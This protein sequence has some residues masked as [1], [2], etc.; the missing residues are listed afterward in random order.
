MKSVNIL[1]RIFLLAVPFALIACGDDSSSASDDYSSASETPSSSS[2]TE[3]PESLAAGEFCD[4]RDFNVYATSEIGAL[5]WMTGN[6]KYHVDGSKC[7]DDK[8]SNCDSHGRLY[9]WTQAMDLDKSLLIGDASSKVS[10]PH[11]RGICPEGWHVPDTLEWLYLVDYVGGFSSLGKYGF[12]DTEPGFYS[13]YYYRYN[14]DYSFFHTAVE[15]S[16][17][18]WYV[19]YDRDYGLIQDRDY[20]TRVNSYYAILD[21]DGVSLSNQSKSHYAPLRCVK[22]TLLMEMKF[23]PASSSSSSFD[24]P[25]SSSSEPF[26]PCSVAKK[27]WEHLNPDFNYA[28]FIDGRDN[29]CYKTTRVAGLVMLAENLNY[30]DSVAM[31][32]LRGANR[33]TQGLSENCESTGR[34]YTWDAAMEVCPDGWRLPTE[35]EIYDIWHATHSVLEVVSLEM[36]KEIDLEIT[37]AYGLS[38]V[39]SGLYYVDDPYK[40]DGDETLLVKSSVWLS[41]N[42][43]DGYA[44]AYQIHFEEY[45]DQTVEGELKT[46]FMPVRCVKK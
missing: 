35:A 22:D 5:V 41:D 4:T 8:E 10:S 30:A 31:P 19:D 3:C 43:E 32:E 44:E 6:L 29:Q 7:L 21:E 38:F 18:D 42:T 33:C 14:P 17:D 36:R 2:R 46:S 39:P 45:L 20:F 37:D 12:S 24:E 28:V 34:L 9:S 11:H 23:R 26:D 27:S 13:I 1:R 15:D 16:V 40:N 25:E